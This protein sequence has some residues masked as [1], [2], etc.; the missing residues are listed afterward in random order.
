[1][2]ELRGV[3]LVGLHTYEITFAG[4]AGS[5]VRAEFDDCEL[6]IG[7]AATTLRAEVTDQAALW[8]LMQRIIGLG[9]A[10]T[11]LNLVAPSPPPAAG[12]TSASGDQSG[13]RRVANADLT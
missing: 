6:I 11:S 3:F 9:L 8:G 4:Q 5:T 2:G 10:V 7:P 12:G 1:V 13:D